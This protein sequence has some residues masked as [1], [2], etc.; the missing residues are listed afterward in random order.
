MPGRPQGKASKSARG[1]VVVRRGLTAD[2]L[3]MDLAEMCQKAKGERKLEI[4]L[5]LLPY[6]RP[7]LKAIDVTHTNDVR[8]SIT[9]GGEDPA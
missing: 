1:E 3:F 8:V 4:G 5:Q 6:L 9:I 2:E 7:K